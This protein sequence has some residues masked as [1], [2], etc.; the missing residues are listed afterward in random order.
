M[1][2][3]NWVKMR[4]GILDHVQEGRITTTEYTVLLTLILLADSKTGSGIINAAML[5]YWLPDLSIH[6]VRKVLP[7][8]EAKGYIA[9]EVNGGDRRGY[10]YQIDKYEINAEGSQRRLHVTQVVP[11]AHVNDDCRNDV[12]N[13][14]T[15][16]AT[17]HRAYEAT[18]EV[19]H[20]YKKPRTQDINTPI[21]QDSPVKD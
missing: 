1:S 5:R 20:Y 18:N 9:R 16:Q 8:L 11:S 15:Q 2:S 21:H 4:R 3:G 10:R 13:V 12:A 17:N 7:S 19:A 14:I 6:T